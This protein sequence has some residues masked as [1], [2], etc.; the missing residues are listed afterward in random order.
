MLDQIQ[1]DMKEIQKFEG[2]TYGDYPAKYLYDVVFDASDTLK[3]FMDNNQVS[4]I[5]ELVESMIVLT[6]IAERFSVD[7][8]SDIDKIMAAENLPRLAR[9][10]VLLENKPKLAQL[11]EM[12]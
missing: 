11:C 10:L 9:M 6:M 5:W 1:I 8:K 12:L 3:E 4:I 2:D 7:E